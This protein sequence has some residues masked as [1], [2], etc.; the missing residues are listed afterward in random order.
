MTFRC[1]CKLVLSTVLLITSTIPGTGA[2]EH[3]W[4]EGERPTKANF[5]WVAE[6]ASINSLLSGGKRLQTDEGVRTTKEGL[7]AEYGFKAGKYQLW[8]R[9]CGER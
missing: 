1:V 5:K 4:T 3:V 7:V 9:V 6:D 8:V 2:A